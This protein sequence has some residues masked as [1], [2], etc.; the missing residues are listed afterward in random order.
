MTSGD[1]EVLNPWTK[2]LRLQQVFPECSNGT[3]KE[4]VP[5][6][7]NDGMV[8]SSKRESG[9]EG[10]CV[11]AT[12]SGRSE[13]VQDLQPRKMTNPEGEAVQLTNPFG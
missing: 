10:F 6:T 13:K 8:N 11:L 7:S 4:L 1:E 2:V 5:V 3:E 12:K 9:T